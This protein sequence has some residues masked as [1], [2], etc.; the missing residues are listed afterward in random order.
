MTDA[1]VKTLE[2]DL[3]RFDVWVELARLQNREGKHEKARANCESGLYELVKL[4]AEKMNNDERNPILKTFS[5]ETEIDIAG[6][7]AVKGVWY[8]LALGKYESIVFPT[9]EGAEEEERT[10]EHKGL[11]WAEISSD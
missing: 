11:Y 6:E 8:L 2:K 3:R 5:Y 10:E 7:Y 1:L 9:D 4:V